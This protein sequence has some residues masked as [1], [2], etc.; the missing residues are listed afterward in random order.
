[1]SWSFCRDR[2]CLSS[3]A[4]L[5]WQAWHLHV[6]HLPCSFLLFHS[7]ESWTPLRFARIFPLLLPCLFLLSITIPIPIPSCT[8]QQRRQR[9]RRRQHRQHCPHQHQ[10]RSH[11]TCLRLPSVLLLFEALFAVPLSSLGVVSHLQLTGKL[12]ALYYVH[13]QPPKHPG[14]T[15]S[16]LCCR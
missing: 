12:P 1:M 7:P 15:M 5:G 2:P 4:R 3:A 13:T 14:A 9:Q 16:T 10:H 8:P 11:L 6:G